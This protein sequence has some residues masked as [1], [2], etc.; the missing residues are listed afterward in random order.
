MVP[1]LGTDPA[2]FWTHAPPPQRALRRAGLHRANALCRSAVCDRSYHAQVQCSAGAA[3]RMASWATPSRMRWR[4]APRHPSA[5]IPL[6]QPT[7]PTVSVSNGAA[8]LCFALLCFALL[9]F[10]LL[11]L[12]LARLWL[13]THSALTALGGQPIRWLHGV[14]IEQLSAG[15]SHSIARASEAMAHDCCPPHADTHP[16]CAPVPAPAEAQR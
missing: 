2:V 16:L 6:P 13:A 11:W 15:E 7:E 12:G 4:P 10:A 3:T 8:L 14:R 5:V 9:C 1:P